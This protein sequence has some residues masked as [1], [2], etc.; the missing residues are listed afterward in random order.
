VLDKGDKVGLLGP[1]RKRR[2]VKKEDLDQVLERGGSC[3]HVGLGAPRV[4][5]LHCKWRPRRLVGASR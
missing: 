4:R 1:R 2:D 5:S 3:R